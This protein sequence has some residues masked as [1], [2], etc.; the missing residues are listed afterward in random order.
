MIQNINDEIS[1]KLASMKKSENE[2]P[3]NKNYTQL[4]AS[5]TTNE[6]T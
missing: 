2:I 6:R 4:C 3:Q 1:Q 5:E